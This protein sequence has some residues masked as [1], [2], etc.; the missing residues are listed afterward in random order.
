MSQVVFV[1]VFTF[2][3]ESHAFLGSCDVF[4]IIFTSVYYESLFIWAAGTK[5]HRLGGL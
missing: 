5:Y 1:C 3:D 4:D 2:I